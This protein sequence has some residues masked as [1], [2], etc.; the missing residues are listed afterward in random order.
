VA[1]DLGLAP[2][3]F[4][5][6]CL[7]SGALSVAF[8]MNREERRLDTDALAA[9]TDRGGPNRGWAVGSKVPETHYLVDH[10][11]KGPF[12]MAVSW[13]QVLVGGVDELRTRMPVSKDHPSREGLR[14]LPAGK[15]TWRAKGAAARK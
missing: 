3:H 1:V 5:C 8:A 4:S 6:K 9:L 7:R 15:E 11:A 12:S 13:E 2:H 14:G 10:K